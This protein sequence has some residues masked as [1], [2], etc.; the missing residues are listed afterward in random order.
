MSEKYSLGS[1]ISIPPYFI[2]GTLEGISNED[3]KGIDIRENN[4]QSR[5]YPIS[6]LR[7]VKI[8]PLKLKGGIVDLC[9]C[10]EGGHA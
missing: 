9:V 8:R 7:G 4:G 3:V 5:F 1:R 6:E 2:Q 10:V